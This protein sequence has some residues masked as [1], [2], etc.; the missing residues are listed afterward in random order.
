MKN[1]NNYI[2]QKTIDDFGD[3]WEYFTD[4]EGLYGD[5]NFL[6]NLFGPLFNVN[7]IQKKEIL[8]IGSGTGRI[9]EMLLKNKALK[10]YGLE[11]SKK[12]YKVMNK[13]LKSYTNFPL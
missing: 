6:Q 11:P 8:D 1:N 4:S 9:C 2:R 10:V 12:A 13:N 3:Q 5:A 7:N